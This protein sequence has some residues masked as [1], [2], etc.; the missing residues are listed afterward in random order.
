[1]RPRV[2]ILGAEAERGAESSVETWANRSRQDVRCDDQDSGLSRAMLEVGMGNF[3]TSSE[4]DE[5]ASVTDGQKAKGF[6]FKM[7]DGSAMTGN[8]STGARS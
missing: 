6:A 3:E 8:K 7:R 2:L 1:M 4:K 5:A